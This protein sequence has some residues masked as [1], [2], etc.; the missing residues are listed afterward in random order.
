MAPLLLLAPPTG[1]GA[2]APAVYPGPVLSPITAFNLGIPYTAQ[3]MI[4]PQ[5]ASLV[6]ASCS[7]GGAGS[8]TATNTPYGTHPHQQ[9]QLQ[10]HQQ[11]QL[12]CGVLCLR[13]PSPLTVEPLASALRSMALHTIRPAGSAPGPIPGPGPGPGGTT[14]PDHPPAAAVQLCKVGTA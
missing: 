9:Q 1:A 8:S 12:D 14:P 10:Q 4:D 5:G 11:Q 13:L 7:E 3:P 2:A 6:P